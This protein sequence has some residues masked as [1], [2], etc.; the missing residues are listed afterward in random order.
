ML[1]TLTR[2]RRTARTTDINFVAAGSFDCGKYSF[3]VQHLSGLEKQTRMR[4]QARIRGSRH[5]MQ[6]DARYE[7]DAHLLRVMLGESDMAAL[8]SVPLEHFD[9]HRTLLAWQQQCLENLATARQLPMK[10]A[11]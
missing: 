2:K 4:I 5:V 10:R 9:E 11:A 8:L 1:T 7:H 3:T 6:F